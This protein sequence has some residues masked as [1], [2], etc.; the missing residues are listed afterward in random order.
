MLV[1]SLLWACSPDFATTSQGLSTC[2]VKTTS[3]GYRTVLHFNNPLSPCTPGSDS[4]RDLTIR[5]E[6]VRLIDGVPAG[7]AVRG[8]WY[9]VA[10]TETAVVAA[11]VR[12]Q[13]RGATVQVS[14][15]QESGLPAAGSPARA[16]VD[17]IVNK[18]ICPFSSGCI[19]T[20][21]SAHAKI[22]TFS[23]TQYP[24]E[25]TTTT[26]NVWIG[27]YNQTD[28]ADGNGGFN[29]SATIYGHQNFYNFIRLYLADMYAASPRTLDYYAPPRGQFIETAVSAYI[30][31]EQDT[32][33]VVNRLDSSVFTPSAGC[34]VRIINPHFTVERRA[35]TNL[36]AGFKRSGCSVQLIV[37]HVDQSEYDIL[38]SAGIPM[39][40]LMVGTVDR[41]HDKLIAVYMK[42]AG[43]TTWAY[44]VYTG[45]HNFTGGSLYLSDDI[46]VRLAEETGT[47]HPLYDAVVAHFNDGWNSPYAVPI[48]GAH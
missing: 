6:L 44:R 39:R 41:V 47:T 28:G 46:F 18:K 24:G 20:S 16:Q 15:D 26:Y 34:V 33:L 1:A 10:D 8:N 30:S 48:T 2:E 22:F 38:A 11:L 37:N 14:F 7:S 9:S 12:A 21:G 42:K 35:V 5:N 45:S 17:Q 3:G 19:S 29:N 13:Q 43:T 4:T 36:I 32:D 40:A 25:T 27:S 23:R 31:P